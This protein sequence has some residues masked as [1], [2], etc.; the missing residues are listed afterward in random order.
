MFPSLWSAVLVATPLSH[1]CWSANSSTH[2]FPVISM[3]ERVS[4]QTVRK[5]KSAG[6]ELT[7]S[8]RHVTS[9]PLLLH[10]SIWHISNKAEAQCRMPVRPVLHFISHVLSVTKDSLLLAHPWI[11]TALR[12][13]TRFPRIPTA[14]RKVSKGNGGIYSLATSFLTSYLHLTDI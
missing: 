9:Q 11:Q 13:C 4:L 1:L 14:S 5:V 2:L 12:M 8:S 3:L 6:V 7:L 10:E